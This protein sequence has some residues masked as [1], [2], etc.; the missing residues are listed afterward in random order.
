MRALI[1]IA[2]SVA[3][4][5]VP[6][7]AQRMGHSNTNAPTVG[8]SLDLA[9]KGSVKLSYTSITWASGTW[10]AQLADEATRDQKRAEINTAAKTAPL[11]TF[12]TSVDLVMNHVR[13]P[14]G[15]HQLAFMLDEEFQWQVVLF[16]EDKEV[17]LRLLLAD[18]PIQS[19]R[20]VL[21]LI[22]GNED[23]TGR[24]FVTFGDKA[25][26]F[27]IA[28]AETEAPGDTA[29]SF[30]CPMHPQIKSAAAGKCPTCGMDLVRG[31]K[32][33]R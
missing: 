1:T 16:Q 22:A 21:A 2:A 8:Q 26:Q 15:T 4:L 13:V 17:S 18:N 28:I 32:S 7:T 5:A 3:L 20:L 12:T 9:Q 10:A 11:G 23:F 14:A 31:Q 29:E 30:T 6:A 19:T 25:A 24:M 27:S 33:V